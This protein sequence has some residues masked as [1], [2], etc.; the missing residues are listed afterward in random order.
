MKALAA[1][2]WLLLVLAPDL[3]WAGGTKTLTLHE[4]I[5][6]ALGRSPKLA[7]EQYN[8]AGDQEA[9]KKA[10]A[11]LLPSL[12][13]FGNLSNLTGEPDGPFSVLGVNDLDQVGLV[14]VSPPNKVGKYTTVYVSLATVGTGAVVLDYPIYQ[15]GSIFGLNDAPAVAS[16][17]SLFVRQQ[18]TIRLS[19]QAVIETLASTYF[20][21]TAYQRKAELDQRRVELSQK[22]LA[23]F[24]QEFALDMT[25]EQ[26]VELA[27]SELVSD[28]QLLQTSKQRAADSGMQLAELLGRPLHQQLNLD[29][30]EPRI[31]PVPPVD[32]FLSQVA[33]NHPAIGEQ[34]ANIDIAKQ[35][36]RLAETALWPTV[37][38]SA[39]YSI[40]TAFATEN[41][42]LFSAGLHVSIPVWD[43]GHHLDGEHEEQDRLKAAQAALGQ[44]NLE[45]KESI[46]SE[47]SD[48]HT[49]EAS[50]AALQFDYTQAK[51]NFDLTKEQH[52]Q[53]IAT[54]LAFTNAEY[55]LVK[56]KDNLILGKLVL[57]LE[58]VQLQKLSGGVWAWNK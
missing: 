2:S 17:K 50:L 18:W 33:M 6:E 7:S 49:T 14:R 53:G 38:V 40:G 24:Q 36:L 29:L 32:K 1:L 23:I 9:I 37:G 11:S 57:Q 46:L 35:N 34:E 41:P 12:T 58:Y 52:D 20:N 27:K 5:S 28:T 30:S 54:D 8:L 3:S 56:V 22:R 19:E 21:A 51:N 43:W 15:N 26:N 25:L 16:A 31:P 13:A 42:N 10:R 45:L 47:L 4:C 44:V 39:S 55:E 48:I